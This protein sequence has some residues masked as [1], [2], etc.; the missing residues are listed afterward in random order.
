VELELR[1]WLEDE[2]RHLQKRFELREQ[3]FKTLTA[4]NIDMPFE[5]VQSIIVDR[6]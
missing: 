6:S 3:I 5:T 1:V 4:N 2:R